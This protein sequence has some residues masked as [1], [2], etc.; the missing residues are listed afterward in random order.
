[1]K[2]INRKIVDYIVMGSLGIAALGG[3]G[4]ALYDTIYNKKITKTGIEVGGVA[5]GAA[6]LGACYWRVTAA[7]DIFG[8]TKPK[9]D[10]KKNNLEKEIQD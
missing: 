8:A 5:I 10:T 4:Y 2:K 3:A 1:M 7:E 6:I 9:K